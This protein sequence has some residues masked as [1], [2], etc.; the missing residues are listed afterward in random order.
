MKKYFFLIFA[1]LSTVTAIGQ[2]IVKT[3]TDQDTSYIPLKAYNGD[4]R[5]YI[6]HNFIDNKRKYIGKELNV[7]LKDLEL[8]VVSC[9]FTMSD[10]NFNISES[11]RLDVRSTAKIKEGYTT[12]LN[13]VDII[14]V[15]SKPLPYDSIRNLDKE[16]LYLW[17]SIKRNYFGKQTVKNILTTRW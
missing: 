16:H 10:M 15:W 7:L 6:I 13:P 17:T 12:P 2:S 1:I 9:L 5:G 4:A 3:S 14:I 8:Q 11:I